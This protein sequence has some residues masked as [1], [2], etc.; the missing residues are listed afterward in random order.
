LFLSYRPFAIFIV[1][2]IPHR[3]IRI[4]GTPNPIP[5]PRPILLS[6]DRPLEDEVAD[7]WTVAPL[8]LSP[9]E[10]AVVPVAADVAVEVGDVIVSEAVKL[11]VGR[12]I[13]DRVSLGAGMAAKIALSYAISSGHKTIFEREYLTLQLY[14]AIT[15]TLTGVLFV[16]DPPITF[17][18]PWNDVSGEILTPASMG[19]Y[20]AIE[21]NIDN[22][23]TECRN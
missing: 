17:Q 3:L 7:G 5:R 1:T 14:Y 16:A 4:V 13:E 15:I 21:G 11:P 12:V 9:A 2:Q 18:V 20:S 22:K 10:V 23:L 19:A 6:D 8:P